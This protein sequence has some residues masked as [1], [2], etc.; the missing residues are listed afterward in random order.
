MKHERRLFGERT[1]VALM[2]RRLSAAQTERPDCGVDRRTSRSLLELLPACGPWL[3]NKM[4]KLF[5]E[6]SEKT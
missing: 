1:A 3:A 6:V 5:E 2:V 4:T